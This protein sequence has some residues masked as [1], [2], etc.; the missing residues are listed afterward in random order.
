MRIVVSR[1]SSIT[2]GLRKTLT[3]I[4]RRLPV[5]YPNCGRRVVFMETRRRPGTQDKRAS[6]SSAGH[7][8]VSLTRS[9]SHQKGH[10]G[11]IGQGPYLHR[12]TYKLP[13]LGVQRWPRRFW[14]LRLLVGTFDSL[15]QQ[16]PT[17]VCIDW[18]QEEP[19][20]WRS[21]ETATGGD[22]RGRD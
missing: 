9:R 16:P 20:P 14:C 8:V 18:Q 3:W 6:I 4:P 21:M 5:R 19:A 17:S 13:H 11:P 7:P 12:T 2:W 10:P 1:T 15:Q 22:T